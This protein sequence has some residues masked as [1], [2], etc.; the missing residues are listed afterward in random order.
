MDELLV[1]IPHKNSFIT[2]EKKIKEAKAFDLHNLK[3]VK[4]DVCFLLCI[5]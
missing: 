3:D 1:T 4:G 5:R 2:F